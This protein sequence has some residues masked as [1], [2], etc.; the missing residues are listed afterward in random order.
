[1]TISAFL[2]GQNHQIFKVPSNLMTQ[3]STK[4]EWVGNTGL[5][6][7]TSVA[8]GY[9][10]AIRFSAGEL[11]AGDEITKVQFYSDPEDLYGTGLTNGSYQIRIFEGGTFNETNGYDLY[12][13]CG[14]QVFSQ[15][16]TATVSGAQEVSLSSAYEIGTGEFWVVIHCNGPSIAGTGNVDESTLNKYLI[17]IN[18]GGTDYWTNNSFCSN[19]PTCTEFVTKPLSLAVYVDDGGT[20]VENSDLSAFFID[21][22]T[23]QNIITELAL[24]ATDD[25]NVLPVIYNVGP[26]NADQVIAVEF[27][28]D[29]TSL[30]SEDFDPVT[31]TTEGYIGVPGG[32]MFPAALM[33]ADQMNT[34][35]LTTFDVCINLTYSGI[36]NNSANNQ[37]CLTIIRS[38]NIN[39]VSASNIS[40]YP[41]PANNVITVANAENSNIVVLNMVGEVVASIENA[42]ANQAIDITNLASGSYFVRVN[43]EVFKVNVVK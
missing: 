18:S 31:G 19:P 8:S 42:S 15:D 23:D 6:G 43:S 4:S 2:F 1:M 14:T 22:E 35:G 12:P 16:Y 34:A 13:V 28:V 32:I 9:D 38:T 37:A 39:S 33:T 5:A 20:Y 3:N 41:N 40:V 27:T 21:N 7:G 24:G 30:G 17:S 36:D 26:D 10:Y 25:L 29:G 11:T